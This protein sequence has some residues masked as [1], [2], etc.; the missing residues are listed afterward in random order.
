MC[1]CVPVLSASTTVTRGREEIPGQSVALSHF[2]KKRKRYWQTSV[3]FFVKLNL[4]TLKPETI[5]PAQSTSV[6]VLSV[7]R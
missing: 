2:R 4:F 1:R 3:F 7:R 5:D 6:L